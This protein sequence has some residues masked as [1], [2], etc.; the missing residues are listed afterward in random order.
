VSG[1]ETPW[2]YWQIHAPV[3]WLSEH[4]LEE[5]GI[6]FEH[7]GDDA[8]QRFVVLDAGVLAV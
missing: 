7:R 8:L 5:L 6:V 1:A 4:P 2:F 3:K